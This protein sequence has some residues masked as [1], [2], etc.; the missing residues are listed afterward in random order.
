ML[1]QKI[2][3]LIE[4][5]NT[6]SDDVNIN[7]ELEF[8]I[9]LTRDEFSKLV[10][11]NPSEFT[12]EIVRY[13]KPY[14]NI[15]DLNFRSSCEYSKNDFDYETKET[16]FKQYVENI[17]INNVPHK[18]ICKYSIE[19]KTKS[20]DLPIEKYERKTRM[21]TRDQKFKYDYTI[22]HFS[23]NVNDLYF[24]ISE[25][26]FY[27][28]SVRSYLN[29]VYDLEI[30]LISDTITLQ[31]V[32]D[33]LG[34]ITKVETI[35]INFNYTSTPQVGILTNSIIRKI[36]KEDFVYL[37]KTDGLRTLL[38]I[39]SKKLYSY[40]CG[41]LTFVRDV[42]TEGTY[43]FDTELFN[44]MYYVFDVYVYNS[45]DIRKLPFID[46][47][48]KFQLNITDI[49]KK[50]FYE[51]KNWSELINYATTR[52][53]GVDG[54][55]LQLKKGYSDDWLK[56]VYS[57]KL[58][59][60]ELN[61][62]D[63]QLKEVSKK[64][65]N[66]YLSGSFYD[67]VFNIKLISREEPKTKQNYY[68][69]LFSSPFFENLHYYKQTEND[70]F[71][72][73]NL[74][75]KIVEMY[76]DE[77]LKWHP[78]RIREDKSHPNGYKVGFSNVSVLF[79][80]VTEP[81]DEYFNTL[82]NSPFSESLIDSFHTLNQEIRTFIFDRIVESK[83]II[84]Q[85]YLNVVD[86]A[87]G[88]G[89]DLKYLLSIGTNNLF[90]IDAD[91]EALVTYAYKAQNYRC[92]DNKIKHIIQNRIIKNGR[93]TFNAIQGFLGSDNSNIINELYKRNEFKQNSFDLIVI[94]YA[95]HYL[96]DENKNQ[97]IKELIR[98]CKTCLSKDGIIL[99]T[100][101]DGNEIIN[102]KGDFGIFK[103]TYEKY[104]NWIKA[105]MPL[106][107]ISSDGYR[108]EP[109]VMNDLTDI[110]EKENFVEVLSFNP[111]Y[112]SRLKAFAMNDKHYT[113]LEKYLKTIKCICF[114]QK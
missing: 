7:Y 96:M 49:I 91:Y 71:Y 5:L 61:T 17:P 16:L 103:I 1:T 19:K 39:Q 79:S 69:V 22:R 80:K 102:N 64:V 37:D 28:P 14:E 95:I 56:G 82:E 25:D 97:N 76:L 110:F 65:Y 84:K 111:L 26:E 54:V 21:T 29:Q 34:K 58:K 53:E 66:L 4:N 70:L 113:D 75:D 13:H 62:I 57:Y 89:G 6:K 33:M 59:P 85:N 32:Y 27:K 108:D 43:I 67:L 101:F 9:P 73:V 72:D 10:P 45:E 47:M 15:K 114:K 63:F 98:L 30:E 100:Y 48:G 31:E 51:I 68:S 40:S 42:E 38:I 77:N 83:L 46:R 81:G 109:L 106:P 93:L 20:F 23:E 60:R 36:P 78:L 3:N 18:L 2:I 107:T 50:E 24:D 55:V 104:D 8:R 74:N 44:D 87:G 41:K 99:I 92:I 94:N 86:I 35:K 88:R 12:D 11:K 112:D 105:R 90:A 52:R